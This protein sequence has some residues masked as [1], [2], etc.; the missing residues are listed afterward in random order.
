MTTIGTD[1]ESSGET[2]FG[3]YVVRV[4]RMPSRKIANL[5]GQNRRKRSC[6][7]A[8]TA[9]ARSLFAGKSGACDTF[10]PSVSTLVPQVT[11]TAPTVLGFVTHRKYQS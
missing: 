1:R 4:E 2:H 6:E 5:A 8:R 7:G 9:V 3:P 10:L 11:L